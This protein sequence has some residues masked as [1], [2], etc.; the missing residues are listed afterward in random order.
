MLLRRLERPPDD[1]RGLEL[2][3]RRRPDLILLDL[4]MPVMHGPLLL[5][6]KPVDPAQLQTAVAVVLGHGLAR[7]A[8]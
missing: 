8:A 4:K 2:V 1:K 6:A 3:S 7:R 5:L